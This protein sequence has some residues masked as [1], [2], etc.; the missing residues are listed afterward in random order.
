[1]SDTISKKDLDRIKAEVMTMV[2]KELL[3]KI[4]PF[5]KNLIKKK[6]KKTSK[7]KRKK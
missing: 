7:K 3:K 6:K 4:Y 5:L 1:M 2:A